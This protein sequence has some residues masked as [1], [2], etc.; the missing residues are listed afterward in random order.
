MSQG[1]VSSV[2]LVVGRRDLG[3]DSE[4]MF[5]QGCAFNG[6]APKS[7]NRIRKEDLHVSFSHKLPRTPGQHV[8]LKVGPCTH[9]RF[10]DSRRA[11]SGLRM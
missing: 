9:L 3:L 7:R 5:G 6:C 11:L 4:Y 8:L 1:L 10:G 2:V